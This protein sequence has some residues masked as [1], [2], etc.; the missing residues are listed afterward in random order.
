MEI[1]FLFWNINNK[2]DSFIS[3]IAKLTSDVDILLLA[4]NSNI[5]DTIIEQHLGLKKV[6][7]I[8]PKKDEGKLTPKFYSKFQLNEFEHIYTISSKRAVLTSL[9]LNNIDEIII[10]GIHLPS[11]L[12]TTISEQ[13]MIARNCVREI[14]EIETIRKHSRT[15]IFGDF[16][17]NPFE[18]GMIEPDAF[19]ATLSSQIAKKISREFQFR[20]HKYF[21]NPMWSFLGDRDYKTGDYKIPGSYYFKKDYSWNMYDKVIMRP[22]MIDIFDFSSLKIIEDLGN[23]KLVD[24]DFFIKSDSYSD[25]LPLKFKINL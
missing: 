17:I 2:D 20:K 5:D 6:T 9:K 3:E 23:E 22:E 16:N 10:G 19:N 12:E 7:Y 21:Y 8:N 11:K 24:N 1:K 25:H 13:T 4:E 14:E 18:P 15:I